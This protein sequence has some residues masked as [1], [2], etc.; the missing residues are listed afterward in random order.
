MGGGGDGRAATLR[1]FD[2][3]FDPV[4][5]AFCHWNGYGGR[6]TTRVLVLARRA[7]L[8]EDVVQADVVYV[9]REPEAHPTQRRRPLRDACHER[10]QL[11]ATQQGTTRDAE[12]GQQCRSLQL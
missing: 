1:L 5:S 9:E 2:R 12:T 4:G 3:G 11:C 10:L 7:H 6:C 8:V